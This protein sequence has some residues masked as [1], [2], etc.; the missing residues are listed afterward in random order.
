MQLGPNHHAAYVVMTF[1]MN[2]LGMM[3]GLVFFFRALR[4]SSLPQRLHLPLTA[5]LACGTLLLPF[6]TTSNSHGLC[7][8]LMAIGLYY[9][10][11]SR[12]S[13]VAA[14]WS[15]LAFA[16][17]GAADHT[18]LAFYGL[19]GVCILLGPG[20]RSRVLWFFLPGVLTMAAT[21]GYY[22]TIGHSIKPFAARPELFVYPG[23]QWSMTGDPQARL[24]GVAWN[25]L[26]FALRYG[27]LLLAGPRRGFLIYNPASWLA[28]YG[29]ALSVWRKAEYW[30]EAVAV[31]VASAVVVGYY[32]LASVNY[33]GWS[34]SIRWFIPFLPLWWFFGSP[35]IKTFDGWALWK[36]RLLAGLV[37]I[38]VFYAVAGAL[39]PWPAPW[40]GPLLPLANV[41]D[42][43]LDKEFWK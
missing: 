24:T 42:A 31:M 36:R 2:G 28:L 12:E 8:A 29:I 32:A 13:G 18:M 25:P 26:S 30:R 22:F 37:A 43:I 1:A 35:A 15:G 21:L 16:V 4:W 38:S 34:Y 27:A 10:L 5:S 3:V 40:H 9:Y 20:R 17:C 6:S 33:S 41:R 11:I 39:N 19:F 7:A 23:S 14:F